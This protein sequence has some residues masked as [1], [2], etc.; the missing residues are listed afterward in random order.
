MKPRCSQK[1]LSPRRRLVKKC[2]ACSARGLIF[3][4]DHSLKMAPNQAPSVYDYESIVD[5]Y[6]D[7]METCRPFYSLKE[8]DKQFHHYSIPPRLDDALEAAN[9]SGKNCAKNVSRHHQGSSTK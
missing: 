4:F 1:L 3:P 5:F 9:Q 8:N 2:V 6:V 7:I